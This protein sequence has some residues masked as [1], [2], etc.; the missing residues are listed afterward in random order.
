MI[1][2]SE[3]TIF[4]KMIWRTK[5]VVDGEGG[6]NRFRASVLPVGG[7]EYFVCG[8]LFTSNESMTSKKMQ[9]LMHVPPPTN[10]C[11]VF[12]AKRDLGPVA[13]LNLFRR[14]RVGHRVCSDVPGLRRQYCDHNWYQ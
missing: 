2:K 11:T 5:N 13:S 10:P 8:F 9:H 12:H 1:T 14:V 6:A 4:L 3:V 7:L